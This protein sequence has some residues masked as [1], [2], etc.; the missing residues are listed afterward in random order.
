VFK[1]EKNAKTVTD[2]VL[3]QGKI[4]GAVQLE[5]NDDAGFAGP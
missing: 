5:D 3:A 2:S 1:D 4:G